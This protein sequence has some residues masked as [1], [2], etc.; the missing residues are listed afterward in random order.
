MIEATTHKVADERWIVWIVAGIG[1]ILLVLI[2][3][4]FHVDDVVASIW[5]SPPPLKAEIEV[6]FHSKN[7]K[8]AAFASFTIFPRETVINKIPLLLYVTLYNTTNT[9][10][11]PK[12]FSMSMASSRS[13]PWKDTCEIDFQG[14]N[15]KLVFLPDMMEFSVG[16]KYLLHDF[17]G[18]SIQGHSYRGEWIAAACK[19]VCLPYIK[20]SIVDFSGVD[21][22]SVFSVEET[23]KNN[24][25]S[26]LGVYLNLIGLVSLPENRYSGDACN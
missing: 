22:T 20:L 15:V 2:W 16:E 26:S 9:T 14:A 4:R 8:D 5:T 17:P 11:I 25:I 18:S 12:Q 7:T 6:G 3:D 24:N 1:G 13:G 19:G 10:I 21:S 23:R